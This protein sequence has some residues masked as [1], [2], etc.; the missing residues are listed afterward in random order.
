MKLS[1]VLGEA[2]FTPDELQAECT[3]TLQD[4]SIKTSHLELKAKIKDIDNDTFQECARKAKD[5]CPISLSLNASISLNAT[6][7]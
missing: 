6:L 3:V 5:E 2:G 4:G 1:F 7:N